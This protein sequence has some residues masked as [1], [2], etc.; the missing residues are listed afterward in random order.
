MSEKTQPE[1]WY[2]II[3]CQSH[4]MIGWCRNQ[5]FAERYAEELRSHR[6]IKVEI[7]WKNFSSANP[8][9]GDAVAEPN[10]LWLVLY[11]TINGWWVGKAVRP[12]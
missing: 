6:N 12:V 7:V 3:D 1:G 9:R 8:D 10:S 2:E 4:T 11:V 5:K